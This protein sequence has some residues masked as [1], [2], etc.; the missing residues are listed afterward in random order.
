MDKNLNDFLEKQNKLLNEEISQREQILN[1]GIDIKN[2]ESKYKDV[3]ENCLSL[4]KNNNKDYY[5][6]INNNNMT[7]E[8]KSFL[9]EQLSILQKEN[10]SCSNLYKLG[11]DLVNYDN[12]YITISIEVLSKLTNID[13]RIIEW[14]LFESSSKKVYLKEKEYDLTTP[15]QFLLFET[16]N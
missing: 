12:K 13:I 1:L 16:Q 5:E 10:N 3:A 9:I 14:W 7:N 2:Y 8:Y 11:I 4:L 15:E 6:F